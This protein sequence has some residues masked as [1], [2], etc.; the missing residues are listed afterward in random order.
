[1]SASLEP[2]TASPEIGAPGAQQDVRK[3]Q[4]R[5]HRWLPRTVRHLAE[6][7]LA[8]FIVEYFVAPQIGGTH[9]ALNVLAS[10]NPFLLV[11]G[12][13]LEVLS[14]V[15]YFEL[16]RVLIPKNSDPGFAALSRIQ[17][18]TLALSHCLP[19]GNAMGYSLGYRLLMR[20]GV[21]GPDV[22]VA[23]AT[24]G[25]GSAVVLNVIFWLA[26]LISLPIYGFQSGYL[27]VAV[28]GLLL[29]AFIAALVILL[30][31][32]DQRAVRFLTAVGRRVP[33]LHPETLPR[34]FG[35]LVA[36]VEALSKDRR[37]LMKAVFLAAAN[38]LFD[39]AS[40]L[41]FLGAFG[42][43]LDPAA[44]LVAYGVANIVAALPITP[45]GLGVMEATLSGI[46]VG[47]GTPRT[48]AIW[49]VIAWR[50]VNFWLPIPLGGLAY[51]S[52]RVHPPAGDQAGLAARRALWRARWR[53]AVDLFGAAT[54]N[55]DIPDELTVIATAID[56]EDGVGG[57]ADVGG[58]EVDRASGTA[59][60]GG[61]TTAGVGAA[62]EGPT[63]RGTAGANG[64]PTETGTGAA[65][66]GPAAPG[67]GAADEGPTATAAGAADEGP[68]ATGTGAA[69]GG[70]TAARVAV[71]VA[72]PSSTPCQARS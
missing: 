20:T 6:L 58:A 22:A 7:L 69:N 44:L 50:L 39:A 55:Q 59:A 52:L 18:S 48:I 8:G 63:A 46:L 2:G 28:A 30:T 45:N 71:D 4:K 5:R 67:A 37:L 53:W 15:A 16:T 31:R 36:R 11:A 68:S 57:G 64:G 21:G 3:N 13:V 10:V 27:F 33:F 25:L 41:V 56:D 43:W 9:K 24:L 51:L 47:F 65:N 34:L 1:M 70:P 54:I 17:L 35:Q 19:G 61:P 32:G 12:L 26:L 49:G 62:N 42:R 29:M 23:L 66:H 14:W 72:A 40:L 38:W 60:N